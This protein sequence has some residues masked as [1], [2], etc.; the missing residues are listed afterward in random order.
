M[1]GSATHGELVVAKINAYRSRKD[2]GPLSLHPEVGRRVITFAI[3]RVAELRDAG[4]TSAAHAS[5]PVAALAE[6]EA[7]ASRSVVLGT[8]VLELALV[9]ARHN[10][11]VAYAEPGHLATVLVDRNRDRRDDVHRRRLEPSRVAESAAQSE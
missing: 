7:K 6:D 4:H 10:V 1:K 9:L 11:A 2:R 5:L 3:A 8:L